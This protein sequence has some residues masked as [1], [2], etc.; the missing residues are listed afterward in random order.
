MRK[1]GGIV[2]LI[3]GIFGVLAAVVTLGVGGIGSALE[4]KNAQTVVW[5]GWG[6]IA[7]SFLTIVLGALC[8]SATSRT[9]GY[10]LL[11][12]SIAGAILGG[13][14]VAIC[15]ALA[16]VGGLLA[17]LSANPKVQQAVEPSPPPNRQ[18]WMALW[19]ALGIFGALA[20]VAGILGTSEHSQKPTPPAAQQSR[21]ALGA[22][23]DVSRAGSF[24][25][26]GTLTFHI[27]AGPPNYESVSHGD[28]PEPSYI[29]KLDAPICAKGDE[30][31]D[32]N[33]A[34]EQIQIWRPSDAG[35]RERLERDLPPL[36]GTT[37][38]G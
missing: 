5:L 25:F 3:A 36:S 33:T 19:V 12:S 13:T 10:L 28:T 14:L 23:V 32:P 9:P 15:M 27:F 31:T 7:F 30:D 37:G 6:G 35:D 1:A 18:N 24:A 4:T 11:L 21:Q 17:A 22:C 34:I 16:F 8:M 20:L 38:S 2:A 29:L 26:E